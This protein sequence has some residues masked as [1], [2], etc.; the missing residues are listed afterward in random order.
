MRKFFVQGYAAAYLVYKIREKKEADEG[1]SAAESFDLDSK[2]KVE[3]LLDKI[4][5]EENYSSELFEFRNAVF[6]LSLK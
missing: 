6:S 1:I 3:R 2:I 5:D 4:D